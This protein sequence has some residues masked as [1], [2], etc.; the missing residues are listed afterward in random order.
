MQIF[1]SVW[2]RGTKSR[3]ALEYNDSVMPYPQG[4]FSSAV[5]EVGAWMPDYISTENNESS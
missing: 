2:G 5:V 4:W 1:G 3:M